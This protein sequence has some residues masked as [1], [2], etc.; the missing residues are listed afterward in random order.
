MAAQFLVC[1]LTTAA[2]AVIAADLQLHLFRMQFDL[3]ILAQL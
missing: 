2:A 1:R 3:L